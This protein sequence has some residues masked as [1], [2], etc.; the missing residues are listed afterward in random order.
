MLSCSKSGY[1]DWVNLGR[2]KY[3]AFNDKYNQLVLDTY[4]K[5]NTWGI[6]S[7]E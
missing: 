7:E 1:Y 5:N 6:R 3:K 2:P 4:T